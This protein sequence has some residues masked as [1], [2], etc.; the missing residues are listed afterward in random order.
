MGEERTYKIGEVA[1]L[2]NL[3]ASALRYWED[4]FPQ[5][6]SI[7]TNKGQRRYTETHIALLRR[8]QQLLYDRGMTIEGA[9]RILER[10]PEKEYNV[11]SNPDPSFMNLLE[12]ELLAI[13]KLLSPPLKQ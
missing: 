2:L 7:R 3:N 4:E 6:A 12:Q 9:R 8:I 11:C 10:C 1:A 13:R 5:I